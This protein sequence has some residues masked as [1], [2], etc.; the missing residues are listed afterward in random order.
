[1]NILN[2]HIKKIKGKVLETAY[3]IGAIA[4]DTGLRSISDKT[5]RAAI[6]DRILNE[7]M[8][9]WFDERKIPAFIC[10]ESNESTTDALFREA[11]SA[12]DLPLLADLINEAI[13]D[14]NDILEETQNAVV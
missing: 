3:L 5:A 11:N 9:E 7:L 2:T 8:S 10:V 1:M 14:W 12:I 4:V 13:E 6:A